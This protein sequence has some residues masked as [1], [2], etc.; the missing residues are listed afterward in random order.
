[1]FVVDKIVYVVAFSR[2]P[3]CA[4]AHWELLETA[5]VCKWPLTPPKH[6]SKINLVC[7]VCLLVFVFRVNGDLNETVKRQ[8]ELSTCPTELTSTRLKE[9]RFY[10]YKSNESFMWIYDDLFWLH[11][12]S[13]WWCFTCEFVSVFLS[14]LLSEGKVFHIWEKKLRIFSSFHQQILC[15]LCQISTVEMESF[16][17]I[18][19]GMMINSFSNYWF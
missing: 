17:V 15:F 16:S 3:S 19:V 7:N 10:Y 9:K 4:A 18:F 2:W 6:T 14:A 1:M 12:T 13:V 8:N 5:G 11:S